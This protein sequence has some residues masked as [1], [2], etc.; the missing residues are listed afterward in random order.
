MDFELAEENITKKN[1]TG[2]ARQSSLHQA[3]RFLYLLL[4]IHIGKERPESK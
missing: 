3:A 1:R 2:R 4:E